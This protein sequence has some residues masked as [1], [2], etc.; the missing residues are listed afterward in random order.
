M[1]KKKKKND[2]Q[3][4]KATKNKSLPDDHPTQKKGSAIIPEKN[5]GIVKYSGYAFLLLI[6][7]L[8]IFLR[9]Y[10]I[11]A[12][13]VWCDEANSIVI[14][15][16]TPAHIITRMS[17]DAS[18]P[19]YY[20]L[21]HYWMEVFGK[22]ELALR[23]LSAL[24]GFLLVIAVYFTGKRIF[25]EPVG[26]YA[27][28]I[29]SVAPIQIMYSQ[30]IRMYSLLPLMSLMSMY[31]LLRYIQ[32][33]K[34]F[35]LAGYGL[36]TVLSLFTHNYGLFLLP[37]QVLLIL[38]YMRE[39][40]MILWW[41]L[42]VACIG[43]LYALWIPSLSGQM[44][45]ASATGWRDDFWKLYG[46]AGSLFMS[47]SSFS[48]GGYQP[49]YVPLNTLRG[50]PILP[51]LLMLILLIVGLIPLFIKKY[52]Q[53]KT[54]VV[55]LALYCFIPLI[56]A[57][58]VS[59]L[60]S[61]IYIPGRTDQ[62]VF[63]A[64]CLLTAVG[65]QQLRPLFLKYAAVIL[66]MIFSV[67]TLSDYY[68]LET[69]PGNKMIAQAVKERLVPGDTIIC[70]A[71][72]RGFLEYYLRDVKPY[73]LFYSYPLTKARSAGGQS[74]PKLLQN[75]AKLDTD[76]KRLFNEVKK[77]SSSGRCLIVYVPNDVN[78]FLANTF[79]ANLPQNQ[80][81]RLGT[82]KQSLQNQDDVHVILIRF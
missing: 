10:D 73:P 64:F 28:L 7:V 67:I 13:D 56:C 36:F 75:P 24:F 44:S 32:E 47:F 57:G 41:M 48:P 71:V 65:I 43:A 72:T 37:A 70:T 35:L 23:S 77:N 60:R 34:G 51:V 8:A 26:L 40:K 53:W 16:L 52:A 21:L 80:M 15:E 74:I 61:S 69:K 22:S 82:F 29:T 6:V 20:F 12:E 50:T 59:M 14:A 39:R 54:G 30:Q 38:F 63:P 27:A 55:W 81:T 1:T 5:H 2:G 46:F 25:S 33:K 62:L 31:F 18:P 11:S 76:A 78:Q 42:S 9:F 3:D 79:M 66:V 68:L 58:V 17:H 4:V 45:S 49:P 19:L